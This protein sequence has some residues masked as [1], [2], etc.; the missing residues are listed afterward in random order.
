MSSAIIASLSVAPAFA[1]V[2]GHIESVSGDVVIKRAG[3]YHAAQDMVAIESGDCVAGL[4]GASARIAL[5]NSCSIK[6]KAGESLMINSE[7]ATCADVFKP[8][9]NLCE[10][11][12]E[13]Q[14]LQS[15]TL[16]LI[17]G[18]VVVAGL[19]VAVATSSG[20]NDDRP[21]SP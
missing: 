16:P 19:G 1:Q 18:A 2:A 8:A 20:S 11:D 12:F 3:E 5:T 10:F 17:F 7:G 9:P 21:T 6:V 15:S 14:N 13:S 4:K